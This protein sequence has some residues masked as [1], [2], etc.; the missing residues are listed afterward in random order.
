VTDPSIALI[1]VGKEAGL[2]QPPL[3]I[4]Y[5]ASYLMKREKV[6]VENI[7][8]ID[9]LVGHDT[10]KEIK[11]IQPDLV[12][13]S[14][15]TPFINR[16]FKLCREIKEIHP[17]A[18]TIIGGPHV[19]ALPRLTLQNEYVDFVVVGEGEIHF[20]NLVR[21]YKSKKELSVPLK[22]KMIKDIDTIPLPARE[23]IDMQSYLKAKDSFP[24]MDIVSTP[25][26]TSRGC[27]Y[28]CVY[29][30]AQVCSGGIIRFNSPEYVFGEIRNVLNNYDT[31]GI[32]FGDDLFIANRE[33]IKKICN[34]MIKEGI[35]KEIVWT[36]NARSDLLNS[37]LLKLMKKAGCAQLQMGFESASQRILDFLKNKTLTVEQNERAI[38]LCKEAGIRVLGFFMIGSPGETMND[39]QKTIDFIDKNPID[40]TAIFITT[41]YPGT[42]LWDMYLKNNS[43]TDMS[44][45]DWDMF[46]Y[47]ESGQPL[48]A[49]DSVRDEIFNIYRSLGARVSLKN[50]GK[51]H[52]LKRIMKR[53]SL[54]LKLG[55]HYVRGG[56]A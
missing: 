22:M 1:N 45:I 30:A 6:P 32:F 3:G 26:F 43:I 51:V 56:I 8:I 54:A 55:L 19:S 23:L 11:K 15:S 18:R 17:D 37:E 42:A 53:P 4:G 5:L 44:K 2:T 36:C 47:G 52:L 10:I 29:C 31:D 50:Y 16:T 49:D 20:S 39:I 24:G 13:F 12:G 40:F 41:P 21:Q 9:E 27:P 46:W 25:V 14:A 33:R 7:K 28:R 38:R 34:M 35:S 48:V